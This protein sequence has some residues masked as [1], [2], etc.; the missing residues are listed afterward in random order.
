MTEVAAAVAGPVFV[1]YSRRDRE[2][3]QRLVGHLKQGGVPVWYDGDIPVGTRW[4]GELERQLAGC[5]VLLLVMSQ[6]SVTSDN[7]LDEL[8]AARLHGKRIIPLRLDDCRPP[9]QAAGYQFEDVS[10]G[11]LPGAKF[12]ADLAAQAQPAVKKSAA[13]RKKA[14]TGEP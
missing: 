9:F 11:R 14:G 12:V 2:Y 6:A 7:V 10:G 4:I 3:V 8:H 5:S 1:S 13:A